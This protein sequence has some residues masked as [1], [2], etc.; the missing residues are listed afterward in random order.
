MNQRYS[1][2]IMAALAGLCSCGKKATAPAP[3]PVPVT[4]AQAVTKTMP[5]A[6]EAMGSVEAYNSLEIIPQVSGQILKLHFRDGDEV[7]KDAL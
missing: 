1:W 2:L 7:Q 4:T 6:V 3:P 5:L